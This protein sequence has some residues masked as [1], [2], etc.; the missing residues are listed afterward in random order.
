MF[1]MTCI[2]IRCVVLM[3]VSVV[4]AGADV[5][6]DWNGIAVDAG[7]RAKLTPV[8][9]S[10]NV[11]MVQVAMFE[12]VNSISPRYKPY[13]ISLTPPAETSAEIAAATAARDVLTRIYPE[14]ANDFST[15]YDDFVKSGADSLAKQNG[16]AF[17]KQVAEEMIK[18]RANDNVDAMESYQPVTKPGVYIPT[19]IPLGSTCSTVTPWTLKSVSQFRPSAPYKLTSEQYARDLNEVRWMGAKK[20]SKRSDEQTT[21]GKF[22]EYTG[23]GTYYPIV[24]KWAAHAK[25]DL[26]DSARVFAL[27]A[28]ATADAYLAVFDAKYEYNFWRPLTAVRNGADDGNPATEA[29]RSWQ[30]LIDTPMHPEYPC[31]HCIA[32]STAANVLMKIFKSSNLVEVELTSPFAPSMTRRVSDLNDYVA[33]IMDAR[34]FGGVHFRQSALVGKKMGEQIA[35]FATNNFLPLR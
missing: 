18:L 13:K 11:A 33:E 2:A 35:E 31:A 8:P 34:V 4:G 28:V 3:L 15:R 7:Y 30:P 32:S 26:V 1:K 22:W 21:I 9:H 23:P 14:Q 6:T 12:A 20:N 25:L 10:R 16:I 24:R 19:V 5:I 27:V 17:G 29:D